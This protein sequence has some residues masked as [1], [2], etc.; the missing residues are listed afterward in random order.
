M[1]PYHDNRSLVEEHDNQHRQ[2]IYKWLEAPDYDSKHWNAAGEREKHTGSW[3][4]QGESCLDWKSQPKSFL[5]LHGKAGAGK[6]ILC[7]TIIREISDHSKSDPS[8]A[9]AFFYFDFRSKDIRPPNLL[10]ALI[11]QLSLK[12]TKT[13]ATTPFDYLAKLFYNNNGQ[14]SPSLEELKSTLK[15]II[16]TFEKNVYIIFDALD[17]CQE[18]HQ[19]L[20][21]IK[22]I[23][24]WNFDTLRLLVTSRYEQDIEKTLRD[25]VSHQVSMDERLVDSDI[26]VYV[27]RRLSD[28]NKL[29]KYSTE[30][31]EAIENTL[32][33]G[34]HGMFRWV[35]CQLDILRKC[36]S[37]HE[38]KKALTNLPKT[39]YETY[40]RILQDIDEAN[41]HYALKLL[42]WL[43]FSFDKVSL[44]QAV[45]VLATDPDAKHGPLFDPDR[46]LDYS[47][48]ILNIC[49]SLV[50]IRVLD[51]EALYP[52]YGEDVRGK[53]TEL[54]LA[55]FSVCEYMTSECLR[56]HSK[57]SFYHCDKKLANTFIAKTCVAYL[58]QFDQHHISQDIWISHPLCS[59]A[60]NY[61]IRHTQPD[62]DDDVVLC[63]LIMR[64][65]QPRV[66][67]TRIGWRFITYMSIRRS[68][69]LSITCQRPG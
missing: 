15:S 9:A 53:V 34:A 65:L 18:R 4:L 52:E 36:R 6:T 67:R 58:L 29:S 33:D 51:T 1:L 39:L 32:M 37:P 42:Q 21:L 38:L 8:V 63:R 10:R 35:V 5:W 61:W 47:K 68:A 13:E 17:E 54:T 64:L 3:F 14:E 45:D 44:S 16:G 43:A 60:A 56:T 48:Y 31:K 55:H 27:S 12:S 20:E 11:K 19:F 46:R 23:H 40:H 66:R 7:S 69:L 59:Y 49:S 25:L 22:E 26:R 41:R 50:T 62:N 28:D 24:G 2:N 30:E 57:L